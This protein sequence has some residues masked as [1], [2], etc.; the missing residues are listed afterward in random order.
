MTK[1]EFIKCTVAVSTN[2]GKKRKQSTGGGM[3]GREAYVMDVDER[4]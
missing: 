1:A 2:N 4:K 3:G